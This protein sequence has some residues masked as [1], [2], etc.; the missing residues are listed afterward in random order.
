MQNL[1]LNLQITLT[2]CAGQV[3]LHPC[4]PLGPADPGMLSKE[5]FVLA[6]RL[7][8]VDVS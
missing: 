8:V 7:L 3:M 1:T 6:R 5:E 2:T 4:L